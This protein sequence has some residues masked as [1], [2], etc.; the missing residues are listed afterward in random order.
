MTSGVLRARNQG[1][2]WG[3]GSAEAEQRL[4]SMKLQPMWK[5]VSAQPLSFW[6]LCAY[7]FFEYVR[8]QSIY[9]ALSVI[10]WT[11]LCIV[12]S[13]V[14]FYGEGNRFRVV[15]PANKA[16]I[17]YTAIVVAS[18]ILAFSPGAAFG[19]WYLYFSWMLIY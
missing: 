13:A 12:G 16:L 2:S 8:P 5:F 10:P 18:T 11:T 17:W 9:P 19:Q 14:A 1:I 3:M 15:S 7:L 4:Y 6:L